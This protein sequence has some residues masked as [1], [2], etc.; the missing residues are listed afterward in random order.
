TF[1]STSL[2]STMNSSLPALLVRL[3]MARSGV[4][5]VMGG[6]WIRS[7]IL[8]SPRAGSNVGQAAMMGAAIIGRAI[9][10]G[11]VA[12]NRSSLLAAAAGAWLLRRR[13]AKR[14]RC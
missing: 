14:A 10:I 8:T 11:D 9:D 5:G 12:R 7:G 6:L 4:A 2:L 3:G 1:Q 13:L